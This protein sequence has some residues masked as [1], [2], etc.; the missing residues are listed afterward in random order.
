MSHHLLFKNI[1]GSRCSNM[2]SMAFVKK[3]LAKSKAHNHHLLFNLKIFMEWRCS[4]NLVY[5]IVFTL[6]IFNFW[7]GVQ[8]RQR[9]PY[10]LEDILKNYDFQQQMVAT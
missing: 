3:P 5:I 10:L 9:G 1:H 6:H 4:I 7:R 8:I 2:I